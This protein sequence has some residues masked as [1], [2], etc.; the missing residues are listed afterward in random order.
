[1]STPETIAVLLALAYVVL[2]IVENRLCWLAG[3]ASALLYIV[4]FTD[5][6]LYMEAALQGVYVAMAGY[7]WLTWGARSATA[8][9]PIRRWSLRHHAL[10]AVAVMASSFVLGGTLGYFTDAAWPIVDS[11]TTLAAL[12]ATYM[13]AQKILE[14]WLWWIVI[15]VVSVG[16]YLSRD[17]HLTA[18]LFCG[19]VILAIAG[20]ITWRKQYR[21]HQSS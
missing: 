9:L 2:A 6:R 14:N 21:Q 8:A 16:L 15:D 18:I 13:V 10:L 4:V 12:V 5:A 7:G 3:G 17:L 20:W 19:Y 11:F 1:V